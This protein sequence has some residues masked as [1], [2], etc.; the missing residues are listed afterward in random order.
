M[1]T[2]RR[3][4][5]TTRRL[6]TAG[7]LLGM[8]V[9]AIPWSVGAALASDVPVVTTEPTVVTTAPAGPSTS[10][11]PTSEPLAGQPT[12]P[13]DPVGAEPPPATPAD[14][15]TSDPPD[16]AASLPDTPA[17][18]VS[19]PAVTLPPSDPRAAAEEPSPT[20]PAGVTITVNGLSMTGEE[21]GKIPGCTFSIAVTGLPEN[22]DPATAI[23]VT[24]KAVPPMTPEGS[25][26]DLVK[27]N[28][29]TSTT[30]WTHDFPMDAL[31][32]PFTPH[33]NGYHLKVLVSLN[34]TLAG[35]STYWLGCGEPQTGNPTRIL[36]AV[37]WHA[38]DGSM[39]TD[40][41]SAL[42]PAGWQ[43][44]FGLHATSK[45]GT[46][47]CTY[48][49]GSGVLECVYDNPGHGDEPGLV[50]PGNP[51]ATYDVAVGGVPAGWSVDPATLGTFIGRDVC[52]R[53]H[54]GDGHEGDGHEGGGDEESPAAEPGG[55][56]GEDSWVCTHTV[57][58]VE[59]SAP[60][61]VPPTQAVE[62]V[63][64]A[65]P[66]S[67]AMTGRPVA[68]FVWTGSG[69]TLLGAALLG[70]SAYERR[71]PVRHSRSS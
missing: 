16:P 5:R 7:V 30:E 53:G 65:A 20:P 10:E 48:A 6:G 63:E 36:F 33:S 37:E 64:A 35:A 4:A 41:P 22:P 70:W 56:E 25:P 43:Q 24:I 40:A 12:G 17:D 2:S 45:K 38:N 49:A 29:T 26:V 52:P 44:Y 58:L 69:L 66:A 8:V 3:P 23:G 67:L 27:E 21:G 57:V 9:L 61:V 68:G 39:S 28:F 50:V 60:P 54:E 32:T 71:R 15:G 47:E 59:A 18:P 51:E 11:P 34:G 46:A 55:D 42:L 31:V 19:E 62:A 13:A 1:R 14:P